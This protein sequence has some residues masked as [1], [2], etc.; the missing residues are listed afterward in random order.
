MLW[1]RAF[2]TRGSWHTGKAMQIKNS[3]IM[4][5]TGMVLLFFYAGCISARELIRS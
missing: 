4:P 2:P 5:Y 3:R 1:P